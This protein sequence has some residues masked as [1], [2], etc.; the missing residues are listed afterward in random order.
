M[1]YL[2]VIIYSDW[3]DE[4]GESRQTCFIIFIFVAIIVDAI[5]VIICF[6][7]QHHTLYSILASLPGGFD[8]TRLSVTY[9]KISPNTVK[10]RDTAGERRRRRRRG[11][12]RRR[13]AQ[14]VV[15]MRITALFL[16]LLLANEGQLTGNANDCKPLSKVTS[17]MSLV[18]VVLCHAFPATIALK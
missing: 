14:S 11:R 1:V 4:I 6:C 12:R 18:F 5:I 16:M 9:A 3:R 15:M 7:C 17:T 10:P 13:H 8:F 2:L